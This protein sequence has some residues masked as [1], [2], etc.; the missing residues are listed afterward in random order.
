[1]CRSILTALIFTC[2]A[3]RSIEASVTV[4]V[5]GGIPDGFAPPNEPASPS[6]N[7]LSHSPYGS[8]LFFYDPVPGVTP[9]YSSDLVLLHS[10]LMP[11][12][13][14]LGGTIAM[15]VRAGTGNVANDS[16]ALGFA[17]IDRFWERYTR[18]FGDTPSGTGLTG[19]T[20]DTGDEAIIVLD[21]GFLQA[22]LRD[23]VTVVPEINSR[24]YL[25]FIVQD[26]TGVDFV[27]LELSVN[28]PSQGDFNRNGVVDVADYPLWREQFG[29]AVP[30]FSG[31]DADG[32]GSVDGVDYEIWRS[33]FGDVL[34]NS[35]ANP[36][37]SVPEPASALLFFAGT[38][39]LFSR[40]AGAR[41]R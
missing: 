40:R 22:P 15:R 33:N 39:G 9:G 26:E 11:P 32:N 27:K 19:E 37:V 5:T 23:N 24:R 4:T 3:V 12:G 31:A 30:P 38:L 29:T 20:W 21:L 14:I 17:D 1:M 35:V 13:E 6:G 28:P 10:F 2:L 18:T 16:F 25:D 7:L 36:A 41:G 34:E 8:G